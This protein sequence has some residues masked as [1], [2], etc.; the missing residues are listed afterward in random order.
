MQILAKRVEKKKKVPT[1]VL[2]RTYP[3]CKLH[4]VAIYHHFLHFEINT[5][6]MRRREDL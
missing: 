4:C 6:D 3:Y 5:C 2:N 1:S